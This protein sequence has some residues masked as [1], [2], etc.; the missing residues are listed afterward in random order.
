[1][2]PEVHTP[3]GVALAHVS[4]IQRRPVIVP[5]RA[6]VDLRPWYLD[7]DQ[8]VHVCALDQPHA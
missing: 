4:P 7:D 5:H 1:M 3:Y 6:V 8:D 2:P